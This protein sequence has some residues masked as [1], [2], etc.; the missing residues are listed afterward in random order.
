LTVAYLVKGEVAGL[1]ECQAALA[2]VEKR[3]RK[4]AVRRGVAAGAKTVVKEAR[5]RVRRR[6]GLLAKSLGSKV[7]TFKNGTVVGIVG[8]RTGFRKVVGQRTRGKN[9]GKVVYENPTQIAHLI[10][11]GHGGPHPAR[12]YPFLRPALEE[13]GPEIA[14]AVSVAVGK[15]LHK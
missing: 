3:V 2:G 14:F 12:A 7:K 8:P 4:A 5:K 1:K 11:K 9:K 6:S 15:E 13:S 10:E